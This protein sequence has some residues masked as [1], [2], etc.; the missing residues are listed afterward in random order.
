VNCCRLRRS[1][2]HHTV[3]PTSRRNELVICSAKTAISF[4]SNL[5]LGASMGDLR[6][7]SVILPDK[8]KKKRNIRSISSRS[9]AP[10]AAMKRYRGDVRLARF[11]SSFP[12]IRRSSSR[13]RA[14]R[15]EPERW[16]REVG[17][18]R[19][20]DG[21]AH[22]FPSACAATKPRA[23][24][25][26]RRLPGLALGVSSAGIAGPFHSRR[27]AG[28]AA[29]RYLAKSRLSMAV[30]GARGNQNV[31]DKWTVSWRYTSEHPFLIGRR[32]SG[33][34]PWQ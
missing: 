25:L 22:R 14:C 2:G 16:A 17:G 30:L 8:K 4:I 15:D 9:K 28:K 5:P 34:R 29:V 13:R 7:L 6:R 19:Q 31:Q 10:S 1:E 26:R 27:R 11:R 18:D 20:H 23:R 3:V 21:Q 32:L 33:W 24:A 12:H